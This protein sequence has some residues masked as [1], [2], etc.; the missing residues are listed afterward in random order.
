MWWGAG[1]AKGGIIKRKGIKRKG[2]ADGGIVVGPGTETSDSVP[3]MVD[4]Q[5]PAAL[6]T[7][8]GVLNA[9]GVKLVGEDFV[10]NI[11]R[12]GIALSKIRKGITINGESRSVNA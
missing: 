2:Y 5:K 11:N 12:A 1:A 6:S 10:H 9:E 4:G 3:A 8:E 7:G